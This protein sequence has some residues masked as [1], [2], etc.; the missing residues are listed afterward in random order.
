MATTTNNSWPRVAA[1]ILCHAMCHVLGTH[2]LLLRFLFNCSVLFKIKIVLCRSDVEK[3]R[4]DNDPRYPVR[5]LQFRM[6][7][8]LSVPPSASRV[9]KQREM[10]SQPHPSARGEGAK[11][12]KQLLQQKPWNLAWAA[13]PQPS[14]KGTHAEGATVAVDLQAEAKYPRGQTSSRRSYG[15]GLWLL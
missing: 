3:S 4:D 6:V 7:P 11:L 10:P 12:C 2:V 8:H 14:G 5:R 9:W 1:F 13:S 15:C